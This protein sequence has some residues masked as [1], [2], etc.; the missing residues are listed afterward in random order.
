MRVLVRGAT[1]FLG[2]HIAEELAR[3]GHRDLAVHKDFVVAGNPVCRSHVLK[4]R[5]D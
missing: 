1:G 4:R 2:S 3:A 5:S